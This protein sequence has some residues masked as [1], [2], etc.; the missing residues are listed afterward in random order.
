MQRHLES[1]Y[2]KDSEVQSLR[3][4]IE[5]SQSLTKKTLMDQQLSVPDD[6]I[7]NNVENSLT[8]FA[9]ELLG[10]A[11]L[12]PDQHKRVSWVVSSNSTDDLKDCIKSSNIVINF[13]DGSIGCCGKPKGR[14]NKPF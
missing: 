8:L 14:P 3:W 11:E 5:S 13:K 7:L 2:E 4:W 12:T 9:R 1:R 10:K 6:S